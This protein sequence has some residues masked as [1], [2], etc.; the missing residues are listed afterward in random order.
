MT[1]E[2]TKQSSNVKSQD[3]KQLTQASDITCNSTEHDGHW[4]LSQLT[5]CTADLQ[6]HVDRHEKTLND[7]DVIPEEIIGK[8]RA[9]IGK[10]NLLISK[11]F[12]QF[13]QLCQ[14][15]IVS[16]FCFKTVLNLYK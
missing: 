16:Y 12:D 5:Q 10:A 14:D 13:N 15:S 8:I 4:F 1:L 7:S 2:N 9:T 6:V 3:E 11:K